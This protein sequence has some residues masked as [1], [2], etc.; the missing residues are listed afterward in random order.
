[1]A[2]RIVVPTAFGLVQVIRVSWDKESRGGQGARNRNSVPQAFQV[3]KS[4]LM[5][6]GGQLCVDASH[7]EGRNGFEESFSTRRH[8]IA[9][10]DGF[11]FGC[12]SVSSHAEGLQVRYQYDRAH[13]GA[14]DRW[15]FNSASGYGESPGRTLLVRSG[16]WVRVCYNGRFSCMDSGNWWYEQITINV[17]WFTGDPFE[18]IFLD[19]EPTQNLRVIADLW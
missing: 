9:V 19:R 2:N 16:E 1:M 5:D 10:A 11:N 6:V 17:A 13:G 4:E 12:V 8:R 18:R 3:P 15:F 14:P 7:W